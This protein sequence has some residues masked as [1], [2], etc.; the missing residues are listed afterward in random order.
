MIAKDGNV[1]IIELENVEEKLLS[2]FFDE[3]ELDT[4]EKI[5]ITVKEFWDMINHDAEEVVEWANDNKIWDDY[6][7]DSPIQVKAYFDMLEVVSPLPP[8]TTLIFD[9]SYA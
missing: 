9:V 8:D 6:G 7:L 1:K 5:H 4:T 3:Q 2:I